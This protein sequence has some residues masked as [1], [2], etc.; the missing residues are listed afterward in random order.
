MKVCTNWTL[1]METD[2][3][4]VLKTFRL[5]AAFLYLELWAFCIHP[6]VHIISEVGLYE[7]LVRPNPISHIYPYPFP[8]A[9]RTESQGAPVEIYPNEMNTRTYWVKSGLYLSMPSSAVVN[10]LSFCF[11][12]LYAIRKTTLKYAKMQVCH[13]HFNVSLIATVSWIATES[14]AY[15]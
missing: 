15:Y 13:A 10:L 9:L 2:F 12:L 3:K 4:S 8:L 14:V 11:M 5:S 6:P 7:V 1:R